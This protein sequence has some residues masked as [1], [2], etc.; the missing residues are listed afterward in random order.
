MSAPAQTKARETTQAKAREARRLVDTG[1]TYASIAD[2]MGVTEARVRQWLGM[3]HLVDEPSG[4]GATTIAAPRR[5]TE[6]TLIHRAVLAM[7]SDVRLAGF[8]P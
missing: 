3:L 7:F 1:L 4:D 6:R 8:E 2:R 5:L